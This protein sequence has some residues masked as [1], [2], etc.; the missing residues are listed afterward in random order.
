MNLDIESL[1][2]QIP[3]Y[4]TSKDRQVLVDELGT[5]SRGGTADYFLSQYRDAFK[6]DML[7]GDGWRGFQLFMFD[8]GD[9]RSVRGLVISNSCDVDLNN[10][11]DFSARVIFAPLVK[12]AAYEAALQQSGVKQRQIDEKLAAIRAQ[13]TS[14]IFFLPSGGPLADDHVVR[15]DDAHSMPVAAHSAAKDRT[16]LFTLSNTG[17]YMLVLKLSIHFCRL[18]EKVN[19][20]N[21]LSTV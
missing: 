10:R 20:K 13:K 7:Q 14:S 21:T 5:I 15:L 4:L 9:R 3:Y 8:T 17:F 1:Q 16:K 12:L 11:R 6:S 2:Q 18:H 19:R